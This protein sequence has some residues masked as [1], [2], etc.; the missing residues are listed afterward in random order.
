MWIGFA[1]RQQLNVSRIRWSKVAT[2][3]QT[4][5][6]VLSKDAQILFAIRKERLISKKWEY[7]SSEVRRELETLGAHT[8][9]VTAKN[10]DASLI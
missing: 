9:P 4:V 7:V 5:G 2:H 3:P 8:I 1:K 6:K 10:I